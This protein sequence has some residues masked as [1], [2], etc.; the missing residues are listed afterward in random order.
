MLYKA[1]STILAAHAL[2]I[3]GGID[4]RYAMLVCYSSNS[5]FLCPV[6][7]L[8]HAVTV[9]KGHD[10][11]C[12]THGYQLFLNIEKC[13]V[14]ETFCDFFTH[15]DVQALIDLYSMTN[16]RKEECFSFTTSLS[17]KQAPLNLLESFC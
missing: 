3:P 14:R 16:V 7:G 8:N 1:H 4:Y 17:H 12:L 13:E 9:E 2:A 10:W 11:C 15:H 6:T 5:A